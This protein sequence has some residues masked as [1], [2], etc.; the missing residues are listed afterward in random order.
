MK[1]IKRLPIAFP[2]IYGYLGHAYPLAIMAQSDHYLP[3]FYS[4]YIHLYCGSDFPKDMSHNSI[5]NFY[6]Y[7]FKGYEGPINS[8]WTNA[9]GVDG[10]IFEGYRGAPIEFIIDC[11]DNGQYVEVNVDEF[12]IPNTA[13]Y[14]NNRYKHQLIL[15]GYNMRE[16]TIYGLG[17]V[18]N[19]NMEE[20]PVKFIELV[21]SLRSY[22]DRG[23][24]LALCNLWTYNKNASFQFDLSFVKESFIEYL[25]SKN[26]EERIRMFINPRKRVYGMAIYERLVLFLEGVITGNILFDIRPIH[27]ILEHKKCMSSRI[28]YMIQ[29]KYLYDQ[30]HSLEKFE[31][32]ENMAKIAKNMALKY[33]LTNNKQLIKR[34]IEIYH[35]MQQEE[36]NAIHII[37]DSLNEKT[38]Q[39]T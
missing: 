15:Y 37:V 11:I 19:G 3:W 26:L 27:T 25:E 24:E 29:H 9:F 28:K 39:A 8:P 22:S 21:K 10:R 12:Y 20:I 16:Q 38:I 30:Y 35:K 32:I 13:A 17:F 6:S 14:G 1:E 31:L 23:D 18:K 2:P 5:L 34:I 4:N 33:H 7:A 36:C